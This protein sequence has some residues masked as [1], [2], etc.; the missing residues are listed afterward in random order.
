MRLRLAA[1]DKLKLDTGQMDRMPDSII[2]HPTLYKAKECQVLHIL[3]DEGLVQVRHV[4]PLGVFLGSA[5]Q[6]SCIKP[7]R[8]DYWL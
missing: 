3:G 8:Q 4:G 5:A 7:T 1:W 2:Q 6:L